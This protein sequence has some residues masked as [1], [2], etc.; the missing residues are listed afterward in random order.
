[1]Y[2]TSVAPIPQCPY[3]GRV[4]HQYIEQCPNVQKVDCSRHDLIARL[5]AFAENHHDPDSAVCSLDDNE[6][7]LVKE[8]ADALEAYVLGEADFRAAIEAS[9]SWNDA[10]SAAICLNGM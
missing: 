3:C 2:E 10:Q 9:A 8:A 1:M 6:A 5:R 7:G 4:P